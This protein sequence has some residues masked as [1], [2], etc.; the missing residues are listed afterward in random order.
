MLRK[1]DGICHFL[2][3]DSISTI[4]KGF[5]KITLVSSDRVKEERNL[6]KKQE[7][8]HRAGMRLFMLVMLVEFE[9]AASPERA[10]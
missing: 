8:G 4:E 1:W 6:W 3:A 2:R 7:G 5:A 9:E 10:G